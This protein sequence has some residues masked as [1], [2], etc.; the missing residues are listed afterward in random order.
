M[1][2]CIPLL[3]IQLLLAFLPVAWAKQT[4]PAPNVKAD[5]R[6]QFT[7]V[8][9]HVQEQ[10]KPGGRFSSVNPAQRDIVTRDL[11]SMQALFDKFERV[12]AMDT[13]AKI[14]LFNAQSEVNAVLTHND[15]D[16]EICTQE[17]PTGSNIPKTTCRKYSDMER[18][19]AETLKA[20]QDMLQVPSV[21]IPPKNGK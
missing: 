4:S 2:Y 19:R 16:R 10:M 6:E 1:K 12:D 17:L 3:L 20:K 15:G 5:T 21:R 11:A 7:V 18:D 13:N 8:A 14:S 9:S